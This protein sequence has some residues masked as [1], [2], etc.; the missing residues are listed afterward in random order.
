M[1]PMSF[2]L[3][4][5][6]RGNPVNS[7]DPSGEKAFLFGEEMQKL[8]KIAYVASPSFRKNFRKLVKNN[9]YS[10]HY[11]LV[12]PNDSYLLRLGRHSRA[13]TQEFVNGD[14][15]LTKIKSN[16]QQK[17]YIPNSPMLKTVVHETT[18]QVENAFPNVPRTS[19]L[20]VDGGKNGCTIEAKKSESVFT[21]EA[22]N[23]NLELL[24]KAISMSSA[25][26]GTLSVNENSLEYFDKVLEL[27]NKLVEE[28]QKSTENKNQE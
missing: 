24:S 25:T 4:G 17:K 7:I 23:I 14:G 11:R 20:S 3:Y 9:S 8:V 27:Y 15:S 22:K 2:N 10:A 19:T 6:V 13:I 26:S 28:S 21:M 12:N 1:D 5:Y 16:L 18:H